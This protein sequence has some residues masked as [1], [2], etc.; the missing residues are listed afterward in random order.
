VVNTCGFIDAAIEESLESI[1]E[2]LAQNGRVIVCGCLGADHKKITSH[3]PEVLAV[4]GPDATAEVMEAI[5]QALPPIMDPLSEL[6]PDRAVRLTPDHYAYLKIAEGC[7]QSCSFC[8]IPSLRGKLASRP[9]G[10]IIGEAERL[11]ESGVK[12]LLVVSQD[13]A[14]YGS[15]LR[16]RKEIING[17]ALSTR[18]VTLANELSK[19]GSWV[20]LHYL[21]P[22]PVID[23]LIPL[24]AEGKIL[25]YL[26]VPLQHASSTILKS[27]QRPADSENALRRIE[28]WREICPEL[29]I[30]STFIVGFP[31]E[32]EAEFGK[33]LDFLDEAQLDRAGAFAYSSVEGA[34]ANNLPNQ[35]DEDQKQDRLERFMNLQSSISAT[36]LQ[37]KVGT[38]ETI[39]VDSVNSS[40]AIGRTMGDAP[41]IDGETHIP[42]D[43]ET[44]TTT[45]L[46]PGELVK[47]KIVAA[48]EHDLEGELI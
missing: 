26:D 8:I 44:L 14:A 21:Y 11:V 31:G 15:D 16:Y 25:P 13:T 12:E 19:L 6:L 24:M 30:R 7:N 37:R 10:E 28:K 20:R 32:S 36:K 39:I 34:A 40:G 35:V 1:G 23:K 46:S 22:Y 9:I 17:G 45:K 29:T 33:L 48:D 4:I 27:M 3:F 18:I 41:E 2:A 38:I 42:E 47:V 43:T 5:H